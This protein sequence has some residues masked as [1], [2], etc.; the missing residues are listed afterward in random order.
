MTRVSNDPSGIKLFM[1]LFRFT[2]IGPTSVAS[3]VPN[4]TDVPICI[5]SGFYEINLHCV[6]IRPIEHTRQSVTAIAKFLEINDYITGGWPAGGVVMKLTRDIV[7][8][9][10]LKGRGNPFWRL[11]VQVTK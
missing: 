3:Y 1:A 7:R 2:V 10:C 4:M 9:E 6:P 8:N 5:T 11:A